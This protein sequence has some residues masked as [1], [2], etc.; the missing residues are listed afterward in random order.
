MKTIREKNMKSQ[1]KSCDKKTKNKAKH[2]S[3]S[4]KN[5]TI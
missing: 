1:R 3:L 5:K 4:M 2:T